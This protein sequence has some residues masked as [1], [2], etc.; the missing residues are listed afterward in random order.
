MATS[1]ASPSLVDVASRVLNTPFGPAHWLPLR[2]FFDTFLPRMPPTIDFDKL[3]QRI[4]RKRAPSYQIITKSG[5]IWGYSQK[6]PSDFARGDAYKF[7]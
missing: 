1:D 7:V 3:M 4:K 2:T 6:Q 5:R